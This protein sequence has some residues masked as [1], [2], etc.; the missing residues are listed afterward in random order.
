MSIFGGTISNLERGLDF[1]AIKQKA[2]AQ[3]IANVDTP[4]YKAKS[5]SF[6][7]VFS[8]AK[9]STISA[10]RTNE[11][12]FNFQMNV[13]SPGVYNYANFRYN[14]NGN[15]VDMDK[16]Q[17]NLATNQIYYNALV[18]RVSGKLNTLQTVIKGG[19]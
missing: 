13:S 18:D 10:N 8:E 14:H 11:K 16:E 2:I 3:N 7:D 1:S 15:G 19:R 17:A 12:H 6:G 5:V 4:N 9:Q